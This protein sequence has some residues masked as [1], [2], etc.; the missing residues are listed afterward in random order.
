MDWIADYHTHT[1]FSHGHGTIEENV[2][3]AIRK[4]LKAVAITDHSFAH[5][6]IGLNI[7]KVRRMRRTI[8][9]L[10]RR[11]Q[12]DIA[13]FLGV[14]AN[15]VNTRGQID[16]PMKMFP[17]FDLLAVGLH[18]MVF[19]SPVLDGLRMSMANNLQWISG[20]R[21]RA[22]A[23]INTR[24]LSRAMERY[25]VDIITHPG[26][27]FPVDLSDLAASAA[28]TRT[29]LEINNSHGTPSAS[30]LGTVLE[31]GA[32][33]VA[34]S[35][36]HRPSHVGS[37]DNAQRIIREAGIPEEQVINTAGHGVWKFKSH[38]RR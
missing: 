13:V 36:A 4:K 20:A 24:T 17:F 8:D 2:Q 31:S 18:R 10:N 32:R 14:E 9:A 6:L 19:M 3:E 5:P 28:S 23:A 27:C 37:F 26:Y 11:F 29:L 21:R 35:D 16:V 12:R 15:I 33:F 22:A 1:W 25:S 7:D 30:A 38:E 34:G